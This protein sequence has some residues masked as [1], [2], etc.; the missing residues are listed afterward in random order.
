MI[1]NNTPSKT[2]T[3][4]CPEESTFERFFTQR[5]QGIQRNCRGRRV[6]CACLNPL[7]G[8][9]LRL[10]IIVFMASVNPRERQGELTNAKRGADDGGGKTRESLSRIASPSAAVAALDPPPFA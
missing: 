8:V 9:R 4:L 3:P 1:V 10:A 5:S 7:V 2:S 6:A